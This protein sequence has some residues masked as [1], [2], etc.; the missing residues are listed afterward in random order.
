VGLRWEGKKFAS[1]SAFISFGFG[2]SSGMNRQAKIWFPPLVRLW[3]WHV[4]PSR[5]LLY[6]VRTHQSAILKMRRRQ[7]SRRWSHSLPVSSAGIRFL[8]IRRDSEFRMHTNSFHAYKLCIWARHL[9]CME[10]D[11]TIKNHYP[12]VCNYHCARVTGICRRWQ[13]IVVWWGC[14]SC[15]TVNC[16]IS[17]W[18]MTTV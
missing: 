16:N 5:R 1:G 4:L 3:V 10:R 14:W 12:W 9:R 11:R 15:C 6:N 8:R 17:M 18:R 7:S 13:M 2:T